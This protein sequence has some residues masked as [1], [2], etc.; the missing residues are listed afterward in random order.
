[1]CD[2]AKICMPKAQLF[3]IEHYMKPALE[4]FAV[5]AP[6]FA[7][8]VRPCLADTT[9]KWTFYNEAGVCFPAAL[10]HAYPEFPV[11]EQQ[12]LEQLQQ[13]LQQQKLAG[14]ED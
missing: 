4:A 9:R 8:M 1:M 3:F 14:E 7:E 13:K 5:V 12:A 11:A 6:T 10:D 2:K